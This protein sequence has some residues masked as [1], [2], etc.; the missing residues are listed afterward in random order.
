[1][2]LSLPVEAEFGRADRRYRL[3][4]EVEH[5]VRGA[6]ALAQAVLAQI[7]RIGS[8]ARVL[9]GIGG[10]PHLFGIAISRF[11]EIARAGALKAEY[12][13]L[14]V[15]HGEDRPDLVGARAFTGEE[16]VCQGLDDLP[17]GAVGILRLVDEDVVET[18]IE[19]VADPVGHRGIR[20]Q[21]CGALDQIVEI[22]QSFARLGLLP[23]QR[24]GASRFQLRG[25]EIRKVQQ[26]AAFCYVPYC[27]RDQLLLAH[28]IGIVL[29]SAFHGARRAVLLQ[30]RVEEAVQRRQSICRI[31]FEPSRYEVAHLVGR[32]RLP[33]I[34]GRQGCPKD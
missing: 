29:L 13:L 32:L 6:E 11:G 15:A 34:H 4:H 2:L 10:A 27:I 24:K 9:C 1:M 33:T 28:E 26:G 23:P 16:I 12:R 30:K 22:D 18:A 8:A 21:V 19:F 3:V 7:S 17:L 5:V 31:A 25:E 14:E 20:Q